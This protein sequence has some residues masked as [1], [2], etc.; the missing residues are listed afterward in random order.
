MMAADALAVNI[1]S[2][3]WMYVS[4]VC[5]DGKE[6]PL[7]VVAARLLAGDKKIWKKTRSTFKSDLV[8]FRLVGR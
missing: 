1:S 6:G 3:R 7:H 8:S 4:E 2:Q 5:N